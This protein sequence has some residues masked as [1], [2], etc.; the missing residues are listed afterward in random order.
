MGFIQRLFKPAVP[1]WG[2]HPDDHKRPAADAPLRRMP[3]PERLYISLQQ[4]IGAPAR[5]IVLVGQQVLK[6]QL[7]AEAQGNISAA[8]H[9]PTSGRVTAVGE[10]TAPH[11]SGLAQLAITLTTDGEERWIEHAGVADPFALDPAEIARRAAAA[12]IVGLG[13]ATFPS[14]VKLRLKAKL[15]LVNGGECEPYLSCDDRLMRER[16]AEVVDGIRIVMHAIGATEARV[17]IEDNKPEALAAMREAAAAFAEVRVVA[18]P[19]RYPMGSEKHL[20]QTLTGQEVPAGARADEIGVLVH[21]VGTCA[22]V[23]RALRHGEPLIERIVTVNGGAVATPGN[24]V[25]PVGTLVAD[26]LAFVGLKQAPARLIL[27][28]PMMGALLPHAQVPIVK[29]ASGVLAFDAAEA[30]RPE[31]G[32]CIRC[33]SCARACPMGLLPLEM[34]GRIGAGDL[35]GATGFGLTDCIA[36]GCCAWVCPSHIRLVQ[37][38]NHAKGELAARGRTKL[39]NDAARRLVEARAARL[40]REAKE[41]AAAAAK[42][43]AERDA[44]K[45]KAAA[46]AKS[47]GVEA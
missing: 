44:A 5:P 6:G 7:L 35:D 34:A 2:I 20:V 39:R 26:L 33:G 28:G 40:E 14:A 31:A 27:G 8:I 25:V 29:G 3:L 47:E 11:P 22:A 23:Q 43:K 10:I 24:I 37:Y 19:A 17:G 38:F 30:A 1:A 46:A 42:R 13:G 21:N 12:G 18:I 36:C 4:H 45:A 15:L 32:P 16:P 41:K 9:A